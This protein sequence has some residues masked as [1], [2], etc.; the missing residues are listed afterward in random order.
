MKV[1]IEMRLVNLIEWVIN[2]FGDEN[3]LIYFLF[4]ITIIKASNL[5]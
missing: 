4:Y 3:C 1:K 5:I 2:Y